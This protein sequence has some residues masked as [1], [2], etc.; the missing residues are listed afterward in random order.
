MP[1]CWTKYEIGKGKMAKET[2]IEGKLAGALGK[3][4]LARNRNGDGLVIRGRCWG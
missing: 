4:N 1:V 3:N 2:R